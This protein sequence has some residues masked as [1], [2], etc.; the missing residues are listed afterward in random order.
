M[1]ERKKCGKN[2]KE[3]QREKVMKRRGK[4]MY[5]FG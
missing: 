3:E 1:S 4:G 5:Y 2:N